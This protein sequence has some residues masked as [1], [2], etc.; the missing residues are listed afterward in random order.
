MLGLGGGDAP[1]GLGL[2]SVTSCD[3]LK[4]ELTALHWGLRVGV[5]LER[6]GGIA[7]GGIVS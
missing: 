6:A 4:S 1:L 5:E 3:G 7:S 2:G